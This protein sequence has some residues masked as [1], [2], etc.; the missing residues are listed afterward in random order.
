MKNVHSRISKA[1][2]TYHVRQATWSGNIPPDEDLVEK[3]I[4]IEN[5]CE[6]LDINIKHGIGTHQAVKHGWRGCNAKSFRPYA[7]R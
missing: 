3:G 1:R 4:G 5:D 2:V 7:L 6:L